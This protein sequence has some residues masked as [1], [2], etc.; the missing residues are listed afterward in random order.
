[1]FEIRPKSSL[2]LQVRSLPFLQD[3]SFMGLRMP[4]SK[5]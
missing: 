2:S 4:R 5:M 1:M 3:P